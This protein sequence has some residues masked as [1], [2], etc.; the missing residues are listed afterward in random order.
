MILSY[1]LTCSQTLQTDNI[2]P[3]TANDGFNND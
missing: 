1:A 2:E 3:D